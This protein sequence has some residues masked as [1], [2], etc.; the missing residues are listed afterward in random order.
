LVT[1]TVAESK[2][3][4]ATKAAAYWRKLE[5]V[6]ILKLELWTTFPPLRKVIPPLPLPE[7]ASS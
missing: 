3:G 1:Q 4:G 7:P 6:T 2:T 5:S